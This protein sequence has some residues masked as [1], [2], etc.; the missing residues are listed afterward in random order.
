MNHLRCAAIAFF[1]A[2][3]AQAQDTTVILGLG[4]TTCSEISEKGTT[5][6]ASAG[7]WIQGY[8]SRAS[9]SRDEDFDNR[10]IAYFSNKDF[11]GVLRDWCAE[12]PSDTVKHIAQVLEL[13]I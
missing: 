10:L 2:S 11:V 12:Y 6:Y 3:T 1:L 5:G 7:T 4:E 8:L 13:N 9:Q